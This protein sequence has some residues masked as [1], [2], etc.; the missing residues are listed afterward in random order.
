M[1]VEHDPTWVRTDCEDPEMFMCTLPLPSMYPY[2]QGLYKYHLATS[3]LP[4]HQAQAFCQA[5]ARGGHLVWLNSQEEMDWLGELLEKD[6]PHIPYWYLGLYDYVGHNNPSQYRWLS[7]RGGEYRNFGVSEPKY[8][9]ERCVT[10]ERPKGYRWADVTC[11]RQEAFVCK[12][13]NKQ[14]RHYG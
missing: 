13:I 8:S 5:T 3:P 1:D 11:H 4:Y 7:G 10:M 14:H 6:Y 12:A 9:G 2:Q